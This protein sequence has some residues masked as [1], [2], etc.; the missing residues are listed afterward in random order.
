MKRNQPS[1]NDKSLHKLLSAWR[2]DAALPPRFKER[3]WE[4]IETRER[5]ASGIWMTAWQRFATL[6]TRP[7]CATAYMAILLLLGVSA[8]CE[9]WPSQDGTYQI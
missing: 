8:G 7:A 3:V 6:L 9:R 2:T 5:N 1:E 4:R